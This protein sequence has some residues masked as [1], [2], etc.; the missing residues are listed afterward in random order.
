MSKLPFTYV[1]S[2]SLFFIFLFFSSFLFLSLFA[3]SPYLF[4]SPLLLI[5]SHPHGFPP[6]E[7][8]APLPPQ[9]LPY[10]APPPPI[11]PRLRP[12]V[13]RRASALRRPGQS[14]RQNRMEP[15]FRGSASPM[16]VLCGSTTGFT[17]GAA[18]LHTVWKGSAWS[19]SWSSFWSPV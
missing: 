3:S 9:A 6:P 5:R 2:F 12:S 1:F 8:P 17:L 10:R 13:P 14:S 15:H 11:A 4:T 7:L 18:V 19:R 16:E